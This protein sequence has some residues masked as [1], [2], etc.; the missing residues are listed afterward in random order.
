MPSHG[1][2]GLWDNRPTN[3]GLVRFA[4]DSE[5]DENFRQRESKANEKKKANHRLNKL[6][7]E[8]RAEI[9]TRLWAV[10][11]V[12]YLVKRVHNTDPVHIEFTGLPNI[13]RLSLSD[14]AAA[15]SLKEPLDPPFQYLSLGTQLQTLE[16]RLKD[17][18]LGVEAI[19]TTLIELTFTLTSG[20]KS[21]L[22]NCLGLMTTIE[23]SGIPPDSHIAFRAFN[24]QSQARLFHGGDIRCGNWQ[25]FDVNQNLT[26]AGALTHISGD[27]IPTDYISLST[28][29]RRVWNFVKGLGPGDQTIAVIDLRIL[30]RLGIAYGSTTDLDFLSTGPDRTAYV[31]KHHF[32]VAGWIPC[33]SVLGFLSL[34][35][36]KELLEEAQIDTWRET[37]RSIQCAGLVL[38]H[39]TSHRCYPL[40]RI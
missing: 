40:N 12:Q 31:T 7:M 20:K 1:K 37:G 28:S 13:A 6:S 25:E 22:K 33:R 5:S 8:V 34:K 2:F 38:P 9:D 24:S 4:N 18:R 35:D 26:R 30:G 32:L 16:Q 36:F 21:Q 11:Y 10:M 3:W 29:P 14:N 17:A 23:I 27:H 15:P 39:L 19:W